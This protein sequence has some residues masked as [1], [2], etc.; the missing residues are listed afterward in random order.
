MIDPIPSLIKMISALLLVLGLILAA[1]FV[2]KRVL[3]G[4]LGQWKSTP[5]MKV[6]STT[7]LGPKKEISLIEIGQEYLVIG[8]TPNNISLLTRLDRPPETNTKP[9]SFQTEIDRF[10]AEVEV[11]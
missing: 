7:Y 8:V 11:K 10:G 6:L 4:R 5:L 3:R 1:A 9:N 2:A